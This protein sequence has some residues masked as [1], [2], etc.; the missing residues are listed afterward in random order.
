MA[1]TRKKKPVPPPAPLGNQYAL[2]NN[3]GRPTDYRPEYVEQVR[4][5]CQ[6]GATDVEIARFFNVTT[7]TYYL[8]KLTYPEFSEAIVAGKA[9]PDERMKRSLYQRGIGYDVP[10]VRTEERLIDDQ[11]VV[12]KRTIGVEHIPGDVGAQK[13]WLCNR[14]PKEWRD[15]QEHIVKDDNLEMTSQEALED[16]VS[17]LVRAG[18]QVALPP[19]VIE[20]AVVE[21]ETEGT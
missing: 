2:G 12:V 4:K 18:V 1:K 6:L 11:M 8:W 9:M 14:M 13:M 19:P 15:R 10:I 16:L 17:L 20:G 5:L 3:G 21:Q 7:T